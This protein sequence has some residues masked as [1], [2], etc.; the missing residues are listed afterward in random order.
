MSQT[1]KKLRNAEIWILGKRQWV[2]MGRFLL[3]K[4][5]TQIY[6]QLCL[7]E[8]GYKTQIKNLTFMISNGLQKLVM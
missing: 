7:K 2:S 8:V 1:M 5:N 3:L 6:E 4:E